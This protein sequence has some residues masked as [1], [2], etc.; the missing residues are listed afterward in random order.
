MLCQVIPQAQS[1]GLLPAGVHRASWSEFRDSFATNAH[2]QFLL[3]GLQRA[4]HLLRLAGCVELFVDGSYVSTKEL[5]QDFDAAWSMEGVDLV[6]LKRLEPVFFEFGF[7]RA[8]QK[9]KFFGEFFPAEM[10]E[11]NSGKPFLSFFQVDK[12]T[13]NSKGIVSVDLRS[14]H[15]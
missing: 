5:P 9:A 14:L 15:D 11:G 12:E 10:Q 13:G 8:A 1:D 4:S 6:L 7:G 2:R 3:D